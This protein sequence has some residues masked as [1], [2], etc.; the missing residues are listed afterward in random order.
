MHFYVK[1][2]IRWLYVHSPLCNYE[3]ATLSR[4]FFFV[5]RV[6]SRNYTR[7]VFTCVLSMRA[8][9]LGLKR[10]FFFYTQCDPA[11]SSDTS[12]S[13]TRFLTIIISAYTGPMTAKT[14]EICIVVRQ[15]ILFSTSAG[16]N[17]LRVPSPVYNI[18]LLLPVSEV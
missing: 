10:R 6:A 16:R 12:L 17:V 1:S 3:F 5:N 2:P 9:P 14:S 11:W 8:K 4:E 18:T 13:I 7:L 15:Y